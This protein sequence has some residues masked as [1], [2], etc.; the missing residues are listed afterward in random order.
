MYHR[1]V[2]RW[3]QCVK[4]CP[5]AAGQRERRRA[6][7]RIDHA[8]ILHEHPAL[9][10]GTD[11]LGESLLG[12]EAF[13]Q[14][15]GL[16]ESPPM[17]LGAF[18]LGEDALPEAIAET[19]ERGLDALYVAEVRAEADDHDDL[20]SPRR[21]PG[22]LHCLTQRLPQTQRPRPSPGWRRVAITAPRP[23]SFA[24]FA[25]PAPEFPRPFALQARCREA[26]SGPRP[27][28]WC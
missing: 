18:D 22:P 1:E 11:G 26:A 8:D 2:A 3:R 25:R 23:S 13:G 17:A 6:R 28:S 10:P 19:I 16:G 27:T 24:P 7:R 15:A 9:E 20:P 21:S 12:G 5:G 14:L 4:P